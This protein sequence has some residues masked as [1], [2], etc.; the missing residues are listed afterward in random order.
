MYV[1]LSFYCIT[2]SFVNNLNFNPFLMYCKGVII[3]N[4]YFSNLVELIAM[5]VYFFRLAFS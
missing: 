2:S 4:I 1:K 3:L 5:F